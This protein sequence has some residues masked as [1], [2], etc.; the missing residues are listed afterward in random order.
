LTRV[1]ADRERRA[2]VG[3]RPTRQGRTNLDVEQA[4]EALWR[5]NETRN[6]QVSKGFHIGIGRAHICDAPFILVARPSAT[7]ENWVMLAGVTGQEASSVSVE[8]GSSWG[9][10]PQSYRADGPVSEEDD[11]RLGV[12]RDR[13][14]KRGGKARE[15]GRRRGWKRERGGER[16][17]A[18][19]RAE[20]VPVIIAPIG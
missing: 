1:R 16:R 20:D 15:D 12:G 19:R 2:D 11:A 3:P 7:L 9:C 17:C 5:A 18:G 8:R 4:D 6:A 14:G 13:H 10:K